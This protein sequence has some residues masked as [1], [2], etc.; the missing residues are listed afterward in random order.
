MTNKFLPIAA[1][2]ACV[3]C[4]ASPV[5]ADDILASIGTQGSFVSGQTTT[6]AAYLS[7]VA[8]QPAPFN[9]FCGAITTTDCSTS[10][11]FDYT[12]PAGDTITGA[13][14]TIGLLDLDSAAT[15]DRVADLTINGDDDTDLTA[16]LNAAANGL[17]G[18]AGS[19]RNEYDVLEITIPGADLTDLSGGSATIALTLQGPGLGVLGTTAH[20]AVGLDFSSLDITATAGS[21]GGGTTP[22]PEAPTWAMLFAGIAVLVTTKGLV[23]R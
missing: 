13:T 7:A 3:L 5:M 2:V 19:A 23:K 4:A 14:L 21:S 1:V 6:S 16:L 12:I 18:G 11:T 20:D 15:S 8:G 10:W 22:T 17:D 9:A